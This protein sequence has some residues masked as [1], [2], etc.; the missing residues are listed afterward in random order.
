MYVYDVSSCLSLSNLTAAHYFYFRSV[1]C[2][3]SIFDLSSWL[4]TS[5]DISFSTLSDSKD[6]HGNRFIKLNKGSFANP[7]NL[8]SRVTSD[9]L[10][11]ET[12][13]LCCP[14]RIP[15]FCASEWRE[16][17]VGMKILYLLH[18]KFTSLN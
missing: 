15:L 6:E 12:A 9:V 3:I 18:V 8:G 4:D 11:L 16:E 13:K 5:T 1:Y 2:H 10:Q 17:N 14:F 7:I